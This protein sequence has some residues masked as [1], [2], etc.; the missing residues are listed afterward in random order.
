MLAH[1]DAGD[2]RANRLKFTT[3]LKGRIRLHVPQIN[4][5]GTAEKENEHAGITAPLG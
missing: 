3:D 4:M 1:V 5:T 2:I